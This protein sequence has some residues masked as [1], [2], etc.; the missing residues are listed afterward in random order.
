MNLAED[1]VDLAQADL[2]QLS[3]E[4]RETGRPKLVTRDGVGDLVLLPVAD[5]EELK[6]SL[7]IAAGLLRG[8]QDLAAGRVS[9]NDAVQQRLRARIA[10][11]ARSGNEPR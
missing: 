5:Y 4:I 8:E 2:K 3:V 11:T 6:D 1:L 10:A 7:E 9:G